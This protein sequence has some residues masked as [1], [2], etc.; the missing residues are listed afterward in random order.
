MKNTYNSINENEKKRILE[1]HKNKGYKT[2]ISEAPMDSMFYPGGDYTK[3]MGNTLTDLL[4]DFKNKIESISVSDI[5]S[6]PNSDKIID[7][8]KNFFGGDVLTMSKDEIESKIENELRTESIKEGFWSDFF[9]KDWSSDN[10][11]MD[12]P[13]SKV[14][15][16]LVQKIGAL[17][18]KIFQVNVLSFGLIG[19]VLTNFL[20][21]LNVSP[22]I[23]LISSMVGFL[24][25][26]II[27]KLIRFTKERK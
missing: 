15:G 25:V 8:V 10:E 7:N 16:G 2:I 12:T 6:I 27:R 9:K 3:D 18:E 17:L 14:K 4:K 23:S 1:M 22:S 20:L 21:N 11:T 5:V 26:Y 24:V 19:S 13:I